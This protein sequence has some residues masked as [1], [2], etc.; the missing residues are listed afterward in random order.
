M[1]TT[2]G[3]GGGVEALRDRTQGFSDHVGE[4]KTVDEAVDLRCQN[5]AGDPFAL[6]R[7]PVQNISRNGETFRSGLFRSQADH[8]PE[9]RTH[10]LVIRKGAVSKNYELCL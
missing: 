8:K 1:Q 6:A 10:I 3:I 2:R 5:A 9:L 7:L 4:V